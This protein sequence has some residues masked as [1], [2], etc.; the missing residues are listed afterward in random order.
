MELF[1][2]IVGYTVIALQ[3]LIV[4]VLVFENRIEAPAWVQAFGRLHPLLLH[5]PIGLLLLTAILLFVERNFAGDSFSGLVTFLLHL[6]SLTASLSAFMGLL[7]SLEGGYNETDLALH[8]WMGVSL[9][10]LCWFLPGLKENRKVLKPSITIGVVLL[11]FTGHYGAN[12]THGENFVLGPLQKDALRPRQ[13]TDSTT[14]F[15]AAIEPVLESKCYSCH[16]EQKAKGRLILTSLKDIE[17]GGKNGALWKP[18]D[19]AHS[20]LMERLTLP[21]TSK[22]HM[23]P[24]DKTQLTAD[25]I[26]FISTWI[27]SGADTKKKLSEVPETDTL[28]K[29]SAPVMIMYYAD[30]TAEPRYHFQFASQQKI[31]ELSTPYRT[32]FQIARN[33]PALQAEFYLSGSF[34]KQY[35]E[36]LS[37]VQEQLIAID[38]SKMPV[39]DEDLRT[40][41]KFDHL[42]KIILNNTA[43][44]GAGLKYLLKLEHLRSVSLSGTK[45]TAGAL[46]E[47]ASNRSI[48][49]I[50]LWN[51]A[52]TL[53]EIADLRQAYKHIR[54]D[55]GYQPDEKER[56]R[57][58]PPFLKND[59]QVLR[60]DEPVMLKHNL[61]GAVIRYTIDGKDA[62]SVS[63]EVY[64]DPLPVRNYAIVKTKAYKD[65]WLSSRQV[66]YVFFKN[67]VKPGRA[68]LLT[69]PD[70]R[71]QGEGATTLIDNK[72]GM[73]DFYRDPA[74][75]AFREAPLEALFFFEGDAPAIT[76][77]TLSYARNIGAMCMP[78]ATL[79][80]WGGSHPKDL[81]LLRRITP[82][83]PTAY[84]PTRIEGAA[85]DIPESSF[86]CYKIVARPLSK[87]PEF[88]KEKKQKGW[89]M[90]DEVFFN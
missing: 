11:I 6:T 52:V 35:L 84:V 39:E 61:P 80:V 38:L 15:A 45:V 62:D 10:F 85:V 53:N 78:P 40:L 54:W 86:R 77:I 4:F 72:K 50:Y 41:A 59:A 24:K 16:N 55:T 34:R 47:L 83:Q 58:S 9:S 66:E 57:L 82:A 28:K 17:K 51:A 31:R 7:L 64:K 32:V 14:L 71:Y 69:K 90:V 75:M 79:E 73:P 56:L 81:R 49:E 48:R 20:L 2:K 63:S 12:L 46:K 42:E 43:I 65:Q 27:E 44:R 5:L 37:S 3:V 74:W 76:N 88:R 23:P 67:G 21:L 87:L 60:S 68:E 19:A 13:L 26:A 25:E 70:S 30:A 29:L 89:L 22:E 36:E 33:E 1:R 8:K 18:G